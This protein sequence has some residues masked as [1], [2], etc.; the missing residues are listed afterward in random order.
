M[1]R[2]LRIPERASC[3]LAAVAL[4]APGCHLAPRQELDDCHRLSQT[5]RSENANLKDQTL[6]L[7]S[8]NQD[9]SERAVDDARRLAQLEATNEQLVTSVQAYQ[10]DRTRL[11]A[12]YQELR[13]S[14]PGSLQPLSARQQDGAEPSRTRLANALDPV[15]EPG[16]MPDHDPHVKQADGSAAGPKAKAP[17]RSGQAARKNQVWLPSRADGAPEHSGESSST[18]R[19]RSD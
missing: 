10:D 6:V 1:A 3:I 5:L 19:A 15:A 9:L 13:A 12:A 14:L 4:A 18:D 7:R 16:P 8:Q 2:A 11:E 17:A